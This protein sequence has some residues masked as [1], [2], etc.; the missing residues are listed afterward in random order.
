MQTSL[1]CLFTNSY[2]CGSLATIGQLWNRESNPVDQLVCV[3]VWLS[4]NRGSDLG[5]QSSSYQNVYPLGITWTLD[6]GLDRGLGYGLDYGLDFGLDSV[7]V[8][9]FKEDYKCWI[10][11]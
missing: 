9:P 2:L 8:L 11:Q 3:C 10:A 5:A 1:F 4:G 7:L 6:S